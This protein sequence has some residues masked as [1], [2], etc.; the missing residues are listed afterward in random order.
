MSAAVA[1]RATRT[2]SELF[3][4]GA[5]ISIAPSTL[6]TV[7]APADVAADLRAALAWRVE[8][9]RA[10][11]R[12]AARLGDRPVTPVAVPG[13]VL[14]L[15]TKVTWRGQVEHW[16]RRTWVTREAQ[17]PLPGLCASCGEPAGYETGDCV[18][19]V[20]ARVGA[21]RA[22][23]RIGAPSTSTPPPARD[24]AAWRDGLYA[25]V[26]RPD[27]QPAPAS[28]A[29]W[30]CEVCGATGQRGRRDVEGCGR[31]ELKAADTLSLAR[32][33]GGGGGGDVDEEV[34]F[35]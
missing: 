3:A 8:A 2:W 6:V 9:M 17:R 26:A 11:I 5:T 18:L 33:G 31:C 7:Q 19:C 16:G 12:D 27:A 30:T 22:E 25:E 13:L 29:P 4:R 21:L 28:R 32:L 24:V 35:E 1:L 34:V 15:A 10:Q 14:P 23:G 20:A